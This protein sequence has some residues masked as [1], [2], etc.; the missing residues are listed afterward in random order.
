MDLRLAGKRVLVTGAS[1]GMGRATALGLAAEGVHLGIAARTRANLEIVAEAARS[2]GAAAVEVFDADLTD[3]AS[4]E[5]VVNGF[6]AAAGGLDG[7]V[8][9]VGLCEV[10]PEGILAHDDGFWDRAY[11]S[12]LMANVRT[13]RLAVPILLAGGGGAIVN[14]TAMSSKHYLPMM[15]HYSAM[16]VALGHFTKN[17]ARE[18]GGRGIRANAVLP[19]MIESEG[20]AARKAAK[21]AETGWSDEEFFQYVNEKYE[22]CTWGSR[23][24]QPEEIAD[25]IVWL[26]SE[27]ASYVNGVWLNVDGGST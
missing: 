6:A 8:N 9:T 21:V 16:K 18:F 15:S 24:G 13:C 25:A 20:V 5:Q 26:V 14:T 22:H 27:R 10:E 23:L 3:P 12:V 17:L 11:Q 7:L 4:A 1:E 2:A 19:G